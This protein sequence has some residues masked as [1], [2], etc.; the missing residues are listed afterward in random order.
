M[1]PRY[2]SSQQPTLIETAIVECLDAKKF[3]FG[4]IRPE[5]CRRLNVDDAPAEAVELAS[6]MKQVMVKTVQVYIFRESLSVK[7][8]AKALDLHHATGF[9]NKAKNKLVREEGEY[10]VLVG[11]SGRGNFER[12]A[13]KI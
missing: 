1:Q 5:V 13:F 7:C 6:G 12:T 4:D 11:T 8:P 9:C 2:P 10:S 3:V